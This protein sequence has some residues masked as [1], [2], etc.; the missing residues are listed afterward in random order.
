MKIAT[1]QIMREIDKQAVETYGIPHVAL[2]ENAGAEVAKAARARI[3]DAAG[4]KICIFAGKGN[5]GGDGFVAARHLNNYGAKVKVY[6]V[7]NADNIQGAAKINLDIL[8]NMNLDVMQVSG[9][10]DWDKMKIALAFSDFLIDGL[11]GTGFKDGL[12]PDME[13]AIRMINDAQK[14]VLAIDLPSG[15]EADTGRVDSIAVRSDL[16]VTFGLPKPGLFFYPGAAYAGEISTADIGLP[17]VLLSGEHIK[18]NLINTSTVKRLIPKRLPD[19]HKGSSGKVLV[20]AGSAG[21][22]GAAALAS[23]AALRSG[24]GVVTLAAAQSLHDLLAVKLTEVM[25]RPLPEIDRGV[26]GETALSAIL[27]MAKAH[28]VI[29]VGPGLG[30]NPSTFRLARELVCQTDKQLI[31]DADA[32]RAF[33]GVGKELRDAKYPPVLTPH[34]G[35]LASLMNVPVEKIKDDLAGIARLAAERY[36]SIVA[37]KSARTVVAHPDGAVYINIRGN[38]GMATA[39]AGDVLAGAIGALFAQGLSNYNA[40]VSGVF[41]HALAGDLAAEK[42]TVGL[43]ATDILNALPAARFEVEA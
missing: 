14:P 8:L 10:R 1:A 22:T 6:I 38:A 23:C 13:R 30:R 31:L 27:E 40:A 2:M 37:L 3:G 43:I 42:K 16:T 32:I 24:A 19:A 29:V 7:G 12:R 4:K 39:G 34:L 20:V 15:V 17:D 5:N 21:L 18:Q 36:R 25:T 35:E 41:L 11:L 9:E 26:I 33:Q 28:D